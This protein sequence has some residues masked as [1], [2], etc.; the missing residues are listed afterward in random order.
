MWDGS[1]M[2]FK[3]IHDV[4]DGEFHEVSIEQTGWVEKL[5]SLVSAKRRIHY[6]SYN[7]PNMPKTIEDAIGRAEYC[8]HIIPTGTLPT[9]FRHDW[10]YLIPA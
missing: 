1:C 8:D 10:H 3:I 7:M 9:Q 4:P 2:N 5:E 6:K